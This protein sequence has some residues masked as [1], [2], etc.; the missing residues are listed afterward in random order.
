LSRVRWAT[1]KVFS[2]IGKKR[3]I[4]LPYIIK[5]DPEHTQKHKIQELKI[6]QETQSQTA[7]PPPQSAKPQQN[8]QAKTRIIHSLFYHGD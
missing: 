1:K 7:K 2:I 5:H 4:L 6:E 8:S 3:N